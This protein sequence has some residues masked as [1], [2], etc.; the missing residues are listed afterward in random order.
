MVL[1]VE[2][3]IPT[4]EEDRILEQLDNAYTK[5]S[6]M[7][8]D[9]RSFLNTMIL[10]N[11]PEKVLEIGVSAGGSS[12]IILNAI[13]N[14]FNAKLY[15]IDLYEQWYKD[16]GKKTGYIVDNYPQLKGQWKLFTGGLALKFMDKIGGDIDFCL[17]DTAHV[18][19]GE[20]FD[21]LMVLP[22]LKEDAIIV[23]H[24]VVLHTYC[25]VERKYELGRKSI[26]NNL[27]M[28]AVTGRKYLQGNYVKMGE[29]YFSNIAGIKINLN[30]KENI[31]EIFNLLMIKWSYLPTEREKN[32]IISY[33]E[34]YYD[35]YFINYLKDVFA[36]QKSIIYYGEEHTIKDG[37]KRIIGTENIKKIK[38]LLGKK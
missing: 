19:P 11:K 18:N 7:T 13:K 6:E 29:K 22:Y 24:D 2:L 5:V 27:L 36:Y 8:T 26:T 3:V 21:I 23:F 35:V 15:S 28:S 16:S 34:K 20:I 17:I 14:F 37:I 33:F 38:R 10:R 25:F 4:D 30:T 9:Q 1:N 12:V 32:E 31:F